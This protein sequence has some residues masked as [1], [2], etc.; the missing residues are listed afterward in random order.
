MASLYEQWA[1]SKGM[2]V[3]A[4]A[5]PQA[6]PQQPVGA[7]RA[8][9]LKGLALDVLPFGRIAEKTINPNAGDV[10]LGELGLEAALT[11][12]PF[13]RIAKGAK[14][15]VGLGKTAAKGGDIAS[16]LG[17]GA[18]APKLQGAGEGLQRTSTIA[19]KSTLDT[20]TDQRELLEVVGRTKEL[21]GS[22]VSKFRSVEPVINR[23]NSEVDS[24]LKGVKTTMPGTSFNRAIAEIGDAITD[25][26]ER[27]AF[28][29]AFNTAYKKVFG[30]DALPEA[31]TAVQV[32]ALRREMNKQVSS[33][34]KKMKVGNPLTAKEQ[35]LLNLRDSLG[36]MIES[37]T[38]ADKLKQ[39]Q[40][41]NRDQSV[42]IRGVPEFKKISEQG[43]PLPFTGG[44]Q[45][46][47]SQ[48]PFRAVQATTDAAGRAVS[49]L[50]G[51]S[52]PARIAREAGGQIGR[53]AAADVIGLRPGAGTSGMG[54]QAPATLEDSIIGSPF[55]TQPAGSYD[56]AFGEESQSPYPRE[57]LLADIQRDPE[58]AKEYIAYYNSLQDVFAPAAGSGLNVTKPSASNL[59]QAQ[60]GLQ[61]LRQLESI[62]SGDPNVLAKTAT[63]GRGINA[64]GIGSFVRN[65]TGTGEFD[66]A[67]FNAV[68]NLLRI[69]TGAAAPESEVRRY[70]SQYLPQPGD[71][72]S[73]VR[74]K[75][76]S[77]YSQF[78]SIVDLA[79]GQTSPT[80]LEDAIMLGR[81]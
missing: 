32:N 21:R 34:F 58:N 40:R 68:E 20:A 7:G 19:P 70:M 47:G 39:V 55:E 24:V 52:A 12:V 38:P 35:A 22:G 60:S 61:S 13:G 16:T 50:G 53:R 43:M 65:A 9:G 81:Y 37:L 10:S 36:G 54:E 4:S 48:L 59:V 67:A 56:G 26:N 75:M 15:A 27:K 1:A 33:A 28:A 41:L 71:S 57:N 62:L 78:Q 64:L 73:V 49:A 30:G 79:N 14:A 74:Q 77:L 18:T 2:P 44:A 66:Q 72:Q 3:G 31:V 25:Q 6:Q 29:N 51:S 17:R 23:L 5:Q 8:G 63:P 46:P 76:N 11:L 42:L 80:G 69:K 45:L